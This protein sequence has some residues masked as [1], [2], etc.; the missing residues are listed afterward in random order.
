MKL[1][2][3]ELDALQEQHL[4]D[5]I[6]LACRYEESAEV[7]QILQAFDAQPP[8]AADVDETTRR[9]T[10]TRALQKLDAL[11]AARQKK[12]RDE[13]TR[14]FLNRFAG[15]AAAI[16]LL[17]AV[18]A[19]MAMAGID[20]LRTEFGWF[21]HLDNAPEGEV[22]VDYYADIRPEFYYMRQSADWSGLYLPAYVP[23]GYVSYD[24]IPV[25]SSHYLALMNEESGDRLLLTERVEAPE[26]LPGTTVLRWTQ[27]DG[28]AACLERADDGGLILTWH[29]GVRWFRLR[30]AMLPEQELL[31]VAE[32][33]IPFAGEEAFAALQQQS[34]PGA[35]IP[36]GYGGQFFPTWTP[37]GFAC[38]ELY[39][40][41]HVYDVKFSA[42][43]G[44]SWYWLEASGD[45]SMLDGNGGEPI[46]VDVGGIQGEMYANDGFIS[47]LWMNEMRMFFVKGYGLTQEEML[48]IAASVRLIDR[49]TAQESIPVVP[50]APT[51]T[52]VPPAAAADW[53]VPYVPTWCPEECLGTEIHVY[54]NGARLSYMDDRG[55]RM[56][57]GVWSSEIGTYDPAEYRLAIPVDIGG[58]PGTLAFSPT[59]MGTMTLSWERDGYYFIL[60]GDG[61]DADNLL[62]VARSIRRGTPAEMALRPCDNAHPLT[63]TQPAPFRLFP[64]ALLETHE[65]TSSSHIGGSVVNVLLQDRG[66]GSLVRLVQLCGDAELLVEGGPSYNVTRAVL[67]IAGRQ[68]TVYTPSQGATQWDPTALFWREGEHQ[69]MLLGT[70]PHEELYAIVG[71]MVPVEAGAVPAAPT[72]APTP[73]PRK[74]EIPAGWAQEHFIARVPDGYEFVS[75]MDCRATWRNADG[76]LF[77]FEALPE[78]WRA[79][80]ETRDAEMVI[81]Q[82]FNGQWSLDITFFSP[83]DFRMMQRCVFQVDGRWFAI[84]GDL[85]WSSYAW[86]VQKIE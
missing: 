56:E 34:V 39:G 46:P 50:P 71:M 48:R 32:S 47:I 23:Q 1:E 14:R 49:S 73:A 69:Y 31:A 83:E 81:P 64:L 41:W 2:R 21:V 40:M 6:R 55:V 53:N 70:I 10:L 63:A 42:P 36:E 33:F 37:E 13:R 27:V 66:S 57:L 19:P 35:A 17:L 65:V 18:A 24:S 61:D 54:A 9:A 82:S 4:D 16:L 79:E 25:G 45:V 26:A 59:S 51:A 3:T 72:P 74:P 22:S 78:D 62:Q 60:S 12:L 15:V 28:H 30:S 77:I 85:S 58:V 76:L 20:L 7:Q 11:E 68:V 38:T 29:N 80:D 84:Q 5:L 52:P 86:Y 8:E 75:A 43:D 44:R 67:E